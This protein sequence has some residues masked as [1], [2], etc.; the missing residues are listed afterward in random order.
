MTGFVADRHALVSLTFLLPDSPDV[1]SSLA[2]EFVVDTGFTGELTLPPAAVAT[3]GLPF[4]YDEVIN[5]AD[6]SNTVVPVHAAIIL[7]QE[8]E[9]EVRVFA[10]G[11]RPLL[12]TAL[13]DGNE[14]VVQFAEQ[15]LVT[16]ELL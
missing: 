15:G 3:L 8:E 6:D 4:A 2:I 11:K 1:P 9:R 16:I 7:W 13:L 10:T 14:F 5:L 12:G